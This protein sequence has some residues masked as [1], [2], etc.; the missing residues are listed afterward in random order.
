MVDVPDEGEDRSAAVVVHL[1]A[2]QVLPRDLSLAVEARD[3]APRR[4][5]EAALRA[6]RRD[7]H[8]R[9]TTEEHRAGDA[10]EET[11]GERDQHTGGAH[12]EAR[13]HHHALLEAR[14]R[15]QE[16]RLA[17]E[18]RAPHGLGAGPVEQRQP[19]DEGPAAEEQDRDQAERG[20][21]GGHEQRPRRDERERDRECEPAP[22]HGHT[23]ESIRR[24]S[25]RV[26]ACAAGEPWRLGRHERA[27]P[28]PE[29]PPR[30]VTRRSSW[31]RY[32]GRRAMPRRNR[33]V[34]EPPPVVFQ[35]SRAIRASCETKERYASDAEARSIALMN[36]APGRPAATRPY[37]CTVCGGWHLTSR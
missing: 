9:D 17:V 16:R 6:Q 25:T 27:L 19:E 33:R 3:D 8:D 10:E 29:C 22:R 37:Q 15:K 35:P 5:E 24:I 12:R 31:C 13:E 4:Q 32:R 1:D 14:Y 26:G 7:A 20:L 36:A 21:A 34:P 23:E 11:P 28:R 30:A 2:C 18:R